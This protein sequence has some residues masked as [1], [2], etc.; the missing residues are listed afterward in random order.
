MGPPFHTFHIL[1]VPGKPSTA[2]PRTRL[3]WARSMLWEQELERRSH[4]CTA[5]AVSWLLCGTGVIHLHSL[6]LTKL[7]PKSWEYTP[8]IPTLTEQCQYVVN[9]YS[10]PYL[11]RA[12][13]DTGEQH[14]LAGL[15]RAQHAAGMRQRGQDAALARGA[16]HRHLHMMSRERKG[17]IMSR[18]GAGFVAYPRCIPP[19]HPPR[20]GRT[21]HP[22]S[23]TSIPTHLVPAEEHVGVPPGQ[24]VNG[25]ALHLEL[26][27]VGAAAL[28]QVPHADVAVPVELCV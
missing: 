17:C 7:I 13:L 1:T 19:V 18:T 12:I 27:G 16:V 6:C 5:A 2:S 9:P 10:V 23:Q 15:S 3:V 21:T 28:E 11:D 26:G 25:L 4:T 24:E 20:A 8:T 22:L 14:I